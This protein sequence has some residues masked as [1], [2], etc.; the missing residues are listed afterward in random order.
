MNATDK[1]KVQITVIKLQSGQATDKDR[2]DA[3]SLL[4]LWLIRSNTVAEEI[5]DTVATRVCAGL[6]ETYVSAHV[7]QHHKHGFLRFVAGIVA[8]FKGGI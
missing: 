6:A 5:A 1:D 2:D 8:V 3:L 4:L 7:E